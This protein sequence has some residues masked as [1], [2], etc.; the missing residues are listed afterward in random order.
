MFSFIKERVW[1]KLEGWKEIYLCRAGRELLIKSIIQAIPFYNK[2]CFELPQGLC[3]DIDVMISRFFWGG[4]VDKRLMHWVSW[5]HMTHP[6]PQGG[7]GFQKINDFSQNNGGG[8]LI[9][10]P[11]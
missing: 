3:H 6:K 8:C 4:N 11:F 10:L 7:F 2:S 1:K 5:D 9:T